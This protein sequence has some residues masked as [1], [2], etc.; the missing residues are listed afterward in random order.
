MGFRKYGCTNSSRYN[1]HPIKTLAST[2]VIAENLQDRET[3]EYI[4]KKNIDNMRKVVLK[5]ESEKELLDFEKTL[6]ENKV[7][8]KLWK[9]QPENI[10]TCIA[11]KPYWKSHISPFVKMLKLFK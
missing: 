9:E 4:N 1:T 8:Y 10:N 6:V 5:V 11:I 2:A 7:V 3:S